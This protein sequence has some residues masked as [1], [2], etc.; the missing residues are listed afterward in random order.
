[1]NAHLNTWLLW[2]A[3]PALALACAEPAGPGAIAGPGSEPGTIV[4]AGDHPL[5][6]QAGAKV[7]AV[8]AETIRELVEIAA[9]FSLDPIDTSQQSPEVKHLRL[10]F[11]LDPAGSVTPCC[12]LFIPGSAWTLV[13]GG[14]GFQIEVSH[15]Q[16]LPAVIQVL[17][18]E[19]GQVVDD[20]TGEIGAVEASLQFLADEKAW[21]LTVEL[22]GIVTPSMDQTSVCSIVGAAMASLDVGPDEV[23]AGIRESEA[24]FF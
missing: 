9:R 20:L 5:Q 24:S 4:L 19:N 16:S 7:E 18:E 22:T 15:P 8:D 6:V 14:G 3:V 21:K 23:S 2:L 1:M 11:E 17:K 10:E 12:I 13:D